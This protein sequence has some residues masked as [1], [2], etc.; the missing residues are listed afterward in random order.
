MT[1]IE[2]ETAQQRKYPDFYEKFVPIAIGI[3]A[4]II[5]GVLVFALGVAFGLI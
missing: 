3:I 5:V 4:V 2:K 1:K